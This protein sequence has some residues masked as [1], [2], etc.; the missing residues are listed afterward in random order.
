MAVL[1]GDTAEFTSLEEVKSSP[2]AA[3]LFAIDGVESVFFSGDFLS[4]TK[5]ERLDWFVLKPSILAGIMEHFAS[6][7]PIIETKNE[8][9]FLVS[10]MGR[11]D[12]KCSIIPASIEG[13]STNQSSRSAFVT[14]RK[15]PLK[16]TD[17]TPSMANSRAA[18]GEDFTSSNEVNSAVS[19]GS[20]ATP[21]RGRTAR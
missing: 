18:R 11:P 9:S 6:G 12:A 10:M 2:L 4:V 7:L 16:K 21:W 19:P 5:A 1:P 13:F 3:R 14:D 15:S 17:S 8:A 20:T